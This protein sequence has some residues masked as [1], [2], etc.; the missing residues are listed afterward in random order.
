[1]TATRTETDSFG[2]L[3]VPADKYWGAQTQRSVINFPIGWERQPVPII[4]ALGVIKKACALVNKAQG[5]MAPELADAIAAAAT[6][7]IDGKFDDN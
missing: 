6:E 7:V 3:D 2:P 4:R 5:D 1:M